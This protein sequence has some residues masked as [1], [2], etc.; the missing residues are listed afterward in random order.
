MRKK[1]VMLKILLTMV[2]GLCLSVNVF[3]QQITVKGLVKDTRI[4]LAS[5]IA[6]S[7]V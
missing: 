4:Q 5:A 2:I 1:N 3:A 6:L 7:I